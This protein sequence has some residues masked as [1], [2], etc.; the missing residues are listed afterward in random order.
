MSD[1]KRFDF[2]IADADLEKSN[3]TDSSSEKIDNENKIRE[4][5]KNKKTFSIGIIKIPF[6]DT[7][8]RY[9]DICVLE[10]AMGELALKA[11][12]IKC[13]SPSPFF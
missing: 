4:T 5:L 9:P 10:L 12:D 2:C 8:F 13:T 6:K 1:Y 7:N 11:F 3:R